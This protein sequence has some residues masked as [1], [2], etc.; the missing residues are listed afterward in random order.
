VIGD[1]L[2]IGRTQIPGF[3]TDSLEADKRFSVHLESVIFTPWSVLGFRLAPFLSVDMTSVDCVYCVEP[4]SLYWGLSSGLRTRNE[5][6]IFG[7][8]ELKVTYIP[9]DE[10]GES[11]VVFSFKQ[12]L[13]VRNSGSFVRAPSLI[14]Y[15]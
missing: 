9:F 10:Y 2:D 15:N 7:T 14:R 11:Q 5:N 6:L 3:S 12:N 13:R 8:I 4:S 1:W